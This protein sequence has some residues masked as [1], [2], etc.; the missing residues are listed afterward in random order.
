MSSLHGNGFSQNPE[1][2][3]RVPELT[4]GCVIS[5]LFRRMTKIDKETQ[6][7]EPRTQNA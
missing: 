4:K 3:K 1:Q 5:I 6:N 7:S 2:N